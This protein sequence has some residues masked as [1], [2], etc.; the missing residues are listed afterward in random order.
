[1]CDSNARGKRE[2]L[3][4]KCGRNA[5]ENVVETAVENAGEKPYKMRGAL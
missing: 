2:K 1:M 4:E 3:R 5:L